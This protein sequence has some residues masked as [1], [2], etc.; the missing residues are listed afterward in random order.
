MAPG[1]VKAYLSFAATGPALDEARWVEVEY[2]VDPVGERDGAL[3]APGRA[4]DPGG[5]AGAVP[6]RHHRAD[7]RRAGA[8][9]RRAPPGG[10]HFGPGRHH[11]R[12]PG[13]PHLRRPAG[14]GRAQQAFDALPTPVVA[15]LTLREQLRPAF[16]FE[17][18]VGGRW[19]T[20]G[21]ARRDGAS[22]RKT[23]AQIRNLLVAAA[24]DPGHVTLTLPDET[25][26]RFA[27]IE[28][29]ETV[30][31]EGRFRRRGVAW[32]L[33]LSRGGLPHRSS[34]YG[35]FDRLERLTFGDLDTLHLRRPG[36]PG[37]RVRRRTHDDPDR[38][39]AAFEQPQARRPDGAATSPAPCPPG[40][41]GR[42]WTGCPRTTTPGA[43]W[44]TRWR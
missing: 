39:H 3:A 21:W 13:H 27:L 34:V 44:A 9:P 11:L 1:D 2:R 6:R 30:P 4:P 38:A 7:D 14:L 5:R 23:A 26:S 16:R 40:A 33:A 43:C 25:A 32:D 42:R 41:T 10:R 17:Y 37:E 12:L 8:L 20:T 35:I 22:D 15:T 19:P 29:Q 36:D 18:A 24:Q 31:P 28:F